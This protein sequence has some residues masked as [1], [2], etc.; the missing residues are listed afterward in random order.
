[1]DKNVLIVDDDKLFLRAMYEKLKQYNFNLV[2]SCSVN[3]AYVKVTNKDFDLLICDLMIDELNG[4]DLIKAIKQ[5][6]DFPIEIIVVSSLEYG[7]KI[8]N[9]LGYDNVKFLHKSTI[10]NEI[11]KH[12]AKYKS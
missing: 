6:V 4:L 1:M 12:L 7:S 9:D 10:F 11:D 3:E 2:S 5:N 8:I